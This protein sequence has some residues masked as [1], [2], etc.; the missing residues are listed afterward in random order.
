MR[1]EDEDGVE[2]LA[3]NEKTSILTIM[4]ASAAHSGNYT[5]R[6]KNSA[7]VTE[8]SAPVHVNGAVRVVGRAQGRA[9]HAVQWRSV[10]VV[11]CALPLFTPP[12]PCPSTR[13]GSRPCFAP[14]ANVFFCGA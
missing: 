3:V 11:F 10:D 5:C 12:P 4:S 7:G 13:L 2:V 1:A 9:G 8:H 14:A 6:A